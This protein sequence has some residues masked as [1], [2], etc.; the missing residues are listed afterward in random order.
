MSYTTRLG[1]KKSKNRAVAVAA[2]DLLLRRIYRCAG[3]TA[4]QDLPLRRIC[5]P[6]QPSCGFLIHG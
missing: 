5:D 1:E 4:A 6:V 2:Q 3:F